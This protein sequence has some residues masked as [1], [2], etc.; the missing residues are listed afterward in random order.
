MTKIS[1]IT[2]VYNSEKYIEQCIDSVLAQSYDDFEL[3]LVNDGSKDKSLEIIEKYA[4]LDKRIRY[5]SKVNEGQGVARNFAL[6]MAKGEYILYLDSDDWLC[7]SALMQIKNKF[8]KEKGT[9]IIF[10]NAYKHFQVSGRKNEYRFNDAYYSKFMQNPFKPKEANEQMFSTCGLPFKA[11]KKDFLVENKIKYS[12]T[13]YIEDAEFY[14]KSLL[15]AKKISCLDEFLVNYRVHEESTTFRKTNRMDTA[16]KV[17]Y[18]CEKI[19]EDSYLSDDKEILHSFLRNRVGQLLYYFGID[20][21]KYKKEDF[22]VLRDAL[23][24]I[25][26]KY[27]FEFSIRNSQ[28]LNLKNIID[29]KNYNQYFFRARLLKSKVLLKS[30]FEI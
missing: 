7:D 4:S 14:I 21:K 16:V 30:Y 15:H 28:F 12:N 17:F 1:I 9:Q 29:A 24:Y 8:E 5:I 27:G 18:I 23:R 22:I 26:E 10:F 20:N 25:Y 2:P 6:N 3:I 13:R 11:Y 19:F